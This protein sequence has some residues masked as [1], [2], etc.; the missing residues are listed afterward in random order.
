MATDVFS[1][2]QLE[3]L[4]D[5]VL[6][7]DLRGRIVQSNER[8]RVALGLASE[9]AVDSVAELFPFRSLDQLPVGVASPGVQV[10][11]DIVRGLNLNEFRVKVKVNSA[12]PNRLVWLLSDQSTEQDDRQEMI[13]YMA[14]LT[15]AQTRIKQYTRQIEVFRH[16]VDGM[17]QGVFLSGAD[18]TISFANTFANALF[19]VDLTGKLLTKVLPLFSHI[20]NLPLEDS[21]LEVLIPLRGEVLVL[22]EIKGRETRCFLNVAPLSRD[23]P[24]DLTLVW[25]LFELTEEIANTQAFID[26]SAELA[27]LNRD[28]ERK[29]DEILRLSRTDFL[30]QVPNRVYS[31]ELLGKALEF[32]VKNGNAVAAVLCSVDNYKPVNDLQGHVEADRLLQEFCGIASATLGESG[33]V[34]RFGIEAFLL[35]MPSVDGA[36]AQKLVKAVQK[37][38]GPS[39]VTVSGGL[40]LAR[41]GESVDSLLRRV[42]TLLAEA[43]K[44]GRNQIATE[45]AS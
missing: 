26:F 4:P 42:S 12:G 40:A 21:G 45:G 35:I 28:L 32:S 20:G 5:N 13:D 44:G 24:S 22:D 30:T 25:T 37:A 41:P 19:G 9:K 43:Q 15:T 7:T 23:D 27:E 36:Q 14:D 39:G 34:G 29:N 33:T 18:K 17:D 3:M 2:E 16:I 6:I 8:A 38:L 11:E 1:P 31:L 10:F